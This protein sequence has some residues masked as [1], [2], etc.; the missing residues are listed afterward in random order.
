MSRVGGKTEGNSGGCQGM[1][2]DGG[3]LQGGWEKAQDGTSDVL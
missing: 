3:R 1:I 2:E